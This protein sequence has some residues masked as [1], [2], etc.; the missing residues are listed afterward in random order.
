[1]KPYLGKQIS[2]NEYKDYQE[3]ITDDFIEK[4]KTKLPRGAT[5]KVNKTEPTYIEKNYD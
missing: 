5:I 4:L 1:V 2:F 3:K